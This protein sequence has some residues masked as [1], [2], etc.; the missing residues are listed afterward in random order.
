MEIR[1]QMPKAEQR[2][3]KRKK[4]VKN[5]FPAG[6]DLE[7]VA[8]VFV[9]LHGNTGSR[10]SDHRFV[11]ARYSKPYTYY[12]NILSSPMFRTVCVMLCSSH[13][14]MA[15]SIY[16][17]LFRIATCEL[18]RGLGCHVLSFDYRGFGDSADMEPT[19]SGVVMDARRVVGR[20]TCC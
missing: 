4:K 7:D 15:N 16:Y 14:V 8:P 6:F 3:K 1:T 17:H 18:I 20:L 2:R 9:Y 19:E 13:S 12:A 11:G 5:R 10:A